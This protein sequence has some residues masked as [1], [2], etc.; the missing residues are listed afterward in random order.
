MPI[1]LM[2]RSILT[3]RKTCHASEDIAAINRLPESFVVT[4]WLQ[5]ELETKNRRGAVGFALFASQAC[6]L[7]IASR[8]D[9]PCE[10]GEDNPSCAGPSNSNWLRLYRH[11]PEIAGSS[12]SSCET[13]M[14]LSS[15]NVSGSG[16]ACLKNVPG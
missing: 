11:G 14:A 5:E 1:R 2:T 10:G 15:W 13:R 3:L 16:H 9:G 6:R 7:N 4:Q 8:A 12:V